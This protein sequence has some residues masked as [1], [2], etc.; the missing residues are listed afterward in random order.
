METDDRKDIQVLS[1][2][3]YPSQ[4]SQ[5]SLHQKNGEKASP[6]KHISTE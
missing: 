4:V 5:V 6:E 3:V 1:A 2:S